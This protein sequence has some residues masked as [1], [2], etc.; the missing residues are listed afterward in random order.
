[1]GYGVWSVGRRA[2]GRKV[3]DEARR[4]SAILT[5][6]CTGINILHALRTAPVKGVDSSFLNNTG[7][8]GKLSMDETTVRL[9][10]LKDL[11]KSLGPNDDPR[12]LWRI[13]E[14]QDY[15]LETQKELVNLLREQDTYKELQPRLWA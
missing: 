10:K 15:L 9:E 14:A 2:R 5:A 7:W 4:R 12:M 3:W 6:R 1:M 11:G 8:S 13:A